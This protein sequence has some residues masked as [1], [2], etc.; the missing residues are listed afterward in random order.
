VYLPACRLELRQGK[1]QGADWAA[2][3]FNECMNGFEYQVASHMIWRD[4]D[5]G[6]GDHRM[7]HDRYH[8]ARRKSVE[9]SRVRRPLR[10]LDGSYGSFWPPAGTSITA[11]KAI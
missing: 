6:L 3:Y 4:A 1:G 9:R 8:A 11:R 7:I 2:G 10:P 5:R